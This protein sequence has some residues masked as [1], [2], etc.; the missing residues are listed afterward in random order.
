MPKYIKRECICCGLSI[1]GLRML[2][3]TD[4]IKAGVIGLD[5][6][7][8][9]L[10]REGRKPDHDTAS[11]VVKR[12]ASENYIAPGSRKRYEDA[13]LKYFKRYYEHKKGVKDAKILD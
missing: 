5:E 4:N 12:L 3:L 7:I 10:Y 8:E 13:V 2:N 11:E 9:D 1:P 6:I